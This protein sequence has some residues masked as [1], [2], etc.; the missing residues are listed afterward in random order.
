MRKKD[1]TEMEYMRSTVADIESAARLETHSL[2]TRV[3]FRELHSK[4][5]FH[6]RARKT[7]SRLCGLSLSVA[8][9][10]A[11]TPINKFLHIQVLIFP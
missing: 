3:N 2:V 5:H 9:C 10:N 8:L 4:R 11:K 6:F 1:A 7:S